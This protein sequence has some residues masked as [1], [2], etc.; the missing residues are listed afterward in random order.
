MA[1]AN[2]QVDLRRV[3]ID[4]SRLKLRELAEIERLLDRKL[5]TEFASGELSMDTMQALLWVEL[6]RQDPAATF[7]QAGDY[8]FAT[9]SAAVAS[10]E[11]DEGDDSVGPTPATPNAVGI[12]AVSPASGNSP[13]TPSSISSGG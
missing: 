11:D 4:P 3:K 13:P 8:D 5:S 12:S 9:L 2:G 10:D 1:G 7:E 6:R